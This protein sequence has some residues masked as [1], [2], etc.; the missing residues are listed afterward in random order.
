[1]TD[2]CNDVEIDN[3][4]LTGTVLRYKGDIYIKRD[5]AIIII[6][7]LLVICGSLVGVILAHKVI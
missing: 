2:K 5:M 1:M 6:V 3:T 7:I 4:D